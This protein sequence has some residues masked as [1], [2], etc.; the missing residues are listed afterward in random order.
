MDGRPRVQ[1][2]FPSGNGWAGT[3]PIVV[4]FNETINEASV[5]PQSGAPNLFLQVEGSGTALPAVYDFLF[6]SRVVV[7]RP[8]AALGGGEEIIT[9]EVVVTPE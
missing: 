3:V 9:Y 7:I 6:G 8:A 2:V 4:E 1:N 5:A